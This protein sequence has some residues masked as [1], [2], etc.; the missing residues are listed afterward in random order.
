MNKKIKKTQWIYRNIT[1][2]NRN[3]LMISERSQWDKRDNSNYDCDEDD[4][5][6]QNAQNQREKIVGKKPNK[7]NANESID[8]HTTFVVTAILHFIC[9]GFADFQINIFIVCKIKPIN[10][11]TK[12]QQ[13]NSTFFFGAKNN[14]CREN[15]TAWLWIA[16]TVKKLEVLI[17]N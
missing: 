5:A 17:K 3:K 13:K 8:A 14:R 12:Q 16:W 4:N 7:Q 1:A 9:I 2:G 6:P 15:H 10:W 11:L